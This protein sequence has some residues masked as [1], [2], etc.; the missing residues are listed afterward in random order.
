[1]K[2]IFALAIL[3]IFSVSLSS[4]TSPANTT[5]SGSESQTGEIDMNKSVKVKIENTHQLAGKTLNFEVELVKLTKANSGS[6]V[7]TVE[8]GDSVEVHYTGKENDTGTMFDTS[9][10]KDPFPFMVGV[11]MMI[12]GFDAGVMGMKLGETKTLI[13][14]PKDAY[15]EK[16]ILETLPMA[17]FS[18]LIKA[19]IKIEAGEKIPVQGANLEILE[20]IDWGASSAE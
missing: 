19:G 15:G 14:E 11:G 17:Q 9:R 16:E 18:E 4:C 7:E 3:S 1:M 2:Y 13:I 8:V 12:P 5:Q 20:V 10:G 6:T